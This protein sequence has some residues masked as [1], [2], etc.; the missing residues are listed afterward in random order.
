MKDHTIDA[1]GKRMGR[2]ASEAAVLLMGKHLPSFAKNKVT[3]VKV[4]IVNASKAY[5]STKKKET[6]VYS[7]H[8]QHLGGINTKKMSHVIEHKGYSEVFRRAVLGMLPKN[9]LRNEMIKNLVVTE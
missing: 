8:S 7:T 4:S 6:K 2:V 3:P 5:I 1:Q 9:K